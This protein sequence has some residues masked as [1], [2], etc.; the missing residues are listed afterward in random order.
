ME[1]FYGQWLALNKQDLTKVGMENSYL[2]VSAI[3]GARV[4]HRQTKC[5]IVG[6]LRIQTFSGV[7]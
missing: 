3:A 5:R 2:G 7:S 6:P 1:Q 4:W